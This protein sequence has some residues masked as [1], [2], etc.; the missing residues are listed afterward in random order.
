MEYIILAASEEMSLG[1]K[2][3]EGLTTLAL[4]LG[5]VFAVLI[6]LW[7]IIALVGK[8]VTAVEKRGRKP[9]LPEKPA[10]PAVPAPAE[11]PALEAPKSDEVGGDE[12]VAVMA[13]AIAAFGGENAPR[14]RI[15]SVRRTTNWNQ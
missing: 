11:K 12:L 7:V 9:A 13:A 14:M 10:V 5:T 6:L 15:R 4:G 2:L 8:A 3:G 1:D